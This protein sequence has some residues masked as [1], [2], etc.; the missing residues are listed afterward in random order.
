MDDSDF[1]NIGSGHL[2]N[3]HFRVVLQRNQERQTGRRTEHAELH[4]L[5]ELNY[6]LTYLLSSQTDKSV[7]NKW[8]TSEIG[9]FIKIKFV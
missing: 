6:N 3:H 8:E 2:G 9:G 1:H 5:V 4:S 7:W